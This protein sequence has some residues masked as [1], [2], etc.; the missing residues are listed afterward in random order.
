MKYPNLNIYFA[1]FFLFETM[2]MA[3]IAAAGNLVLQ[4]LGVAT[5]AGFIPGRMVGALL[6]LFAIYLVWYFM[7]ALPLQGKPEGSGYRIGHRM[8]LAA[9]ILACMVFVFQ[10]FEA[11]I[12]DH[13]T[14]LVLEK[15]TTPFGY[16]A[17]AGFAVGFSLIYQST[18]PQEEKQ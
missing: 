15:I 14:H 16:L 13:N 10:F 6:L 17:M 1:W 2:A 3:W 11:A 4:M 18:L 8:L 9:N 12:T 5:Q 7:R